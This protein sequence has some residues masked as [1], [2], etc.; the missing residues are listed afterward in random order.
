[1]A[2]ADPAARADLGLEPADDVGHR[3]HRFFIAALRRRLAQARALAALLVEHD[4]FDLGAAQVDADA[5]FG[6]SA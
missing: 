5:H 4:A 6:S 1:M 3:R 2:D